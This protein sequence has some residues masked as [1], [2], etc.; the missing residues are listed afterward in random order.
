MHTPQPTTCM[1]TIAREEVDWKGKKKVTKYIV[2]FSQNIIS[3]PSPSCNAFLGFAAHELDQAAD[4]KRKRR[5]REKEKETFSL[6]SKLWG[7]TV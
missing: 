1:M 2:L 6:Q 5:E 4:I 7:K 3:F